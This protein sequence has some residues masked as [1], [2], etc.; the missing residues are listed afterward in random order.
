MGADVFRLDGE[1]A[2]VIGGTGVLGGSMA[3]SLAG[4][5]ARVAILG[6]SEERG[7]E[8]VRAIADSGGQARFFAADALNRDTLLKARDGI[9]EAWGPPTILVNAAGGNR[10]DATLP[11]G[12]DFSAL[13]LEAW[14]GV[15]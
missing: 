6:R 14:K 1:I 3:E 9:K 12:A 2:V 4:A 11:P 5:G 8:R 13:P 15:F 10:P 7:S